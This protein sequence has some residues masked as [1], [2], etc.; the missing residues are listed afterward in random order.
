[1]RV[2]I[3]NNGKS[4]LKVASSMEHDMFGDFCTWMNGMDGRVCNET[5]ERVE[6]SM[7][8]SSEMVYV[9]CSIAVCVMYAVL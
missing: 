1:M 9:C 8:M 7:V 3:V 4:C 6:Q 2:C 5:D